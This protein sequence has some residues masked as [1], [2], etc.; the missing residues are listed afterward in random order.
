MQNFKRVNSCRIAALLV[1]GLGG[2]FGQDNASTQG[3]ATPAAGSEASITR[4]AEVL[5][6]SPQVALVMGSQG[7]SLPGAT[8][9]LDSQSATEGVAPQA[10]SNDRM[11]TAVNGITMASTSAMLDINRTLLV[12]AMARARQQDSEF[13]AEAKAYK[14]TKIANAFL[15][16][17][18]GIAGSGMQFSN[19][20]TVQHAGDW[21]SIA[22]GAVTVL[23]AVCTAGVDELDTP[24]DVRLGADLPHTV[25]AYLAK[26]D[27]AALKALNPPPRASHAKTGFFSCHSE[28]AKFA[29][30]AA[31]AN[32]AQ[33]DLLTA[34][35]AAM[36]DEVGGMLNAV[37]AKVQ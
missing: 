32:A 33:M 16:S 13:L 9:S 27:P 36:S 23:F 34:K 31:A 1:A 22:G 37:Y 5:N 21:V 4:I 15:G 7:R 10:I 20:E 28:G 24:G 11:M 29:Q 14:R 19:S 17:S 26:T 2:A 25:T 30:Q 18:I 3:L 35:L 8:K 12:L 6:V